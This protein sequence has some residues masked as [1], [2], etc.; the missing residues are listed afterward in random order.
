MPN[1][2]MK[3][4]LEAGVHFGHQTRRWNPKMRQYI[5]GARNGIYILDLHQTLQLF[6]DALNFVQNRVMDGGTVLFVGTKK[7]A[8]SAVR[9]AAVRS[10]QYFVTERWLGGML[11]NW[12]TIQAR[13]T[14]LKE[15][16]RM[17]EEGYLDRLPKKEALK[18][19]EERDK[20][21]RY[22]EG[23][24]NM[25]SLPSVM[26]VID[27]NKEIN[28]VKEAMRLRIPVVAIVD[29][30]CDPDV[31]DYVI[32]GNDDAIRSIRLVTGK[33]SEAIVE[34]RPMDEESGDAPVVTTSEDEEDEGA[35]MPVDEEFLTA[36]GV[37]DEEAE[38]PVKVKKAVVEKAP[39]AKAEEA[40]VETP[41]EASEAPS[42]EAPEA[43]E[44]APETN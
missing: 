25:E 32:P 14:R 40:P 30:N 39:K 27:V 26:V 35:A 7:Q 9:E 34:V 38:A 6:N 29:T 33:I 41:S 31:I 12:D 44:S 28:A 17:E 13:I 22:L 15:L 20:L 18:R 19:R 10:G 11:T 8:Q 43:A 36:F 24:R 5:Y 42:E 3:E 2:T 23:I 16:D 4:L 1:L 37:K 21:N